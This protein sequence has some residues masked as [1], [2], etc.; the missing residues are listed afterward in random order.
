V[1]CIFSEGTAALLRALQELNYSPKALISSFKRGD[2]SWEYEYLMHPSPWDP[3]ST[4]VGSFSNMSS[5]QFA[6]A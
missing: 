6:A 3:S 1:A 4:V 5:Q 2:S